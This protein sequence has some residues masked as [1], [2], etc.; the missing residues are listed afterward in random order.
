MQFN[1]AYASA[2]D[3]ERDSKPGWMAEH[4]AVADWLK[5]GSVLDCPVGTGR[6][7]PLYLG[8]RLPFI[9]MDRSE[10][11][12]E[13]CRSRFPAARLL[14]GDMLA[15][16]LPDQSYGTL[17]CVRLLPWLT[18]PEMAE[19]LREAARVAGRAI[20]SVRVDKVGGAVC[21]RGSLTHAWD[22]FR[23]AVQDAGLR[24]ADIR[25]T[26]HS[27]VGRFLMTLLEPR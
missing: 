26:A 4:H 27:P 23:F 24:V 20:V 13:V 14:T 18:P 2:Y 7:I 25:E 17:V 12:L 8:R 16:G 11:M 6:F 3:A 21:W 15:T 9:G 10:A 22:E 1:G 5:E 19:A